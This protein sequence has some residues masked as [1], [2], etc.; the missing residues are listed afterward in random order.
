MIRTAVD[1]AVADLA[2]TDPA[3]AVPPVLSEQPVPAG[4]T[5]PL[6]LPFPF[7]RRHGVLI[8][9]FEQGKALVL[10]RPDVRLTAISEVRRYAGVPLQLQAVSAAEFDRQL[11]QTYERE[12]NSAMQMVEGLGEDT[13]LFSVALKPSG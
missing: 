1:P 10:T 5:R 6:L 2:A 13:D 3:V 4:G 11:Q 9:G 8:I 7:A 12:S